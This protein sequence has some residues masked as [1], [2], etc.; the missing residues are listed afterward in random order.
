[1]RSCEALSKI[2]W[3]P[4]RYY[5]LFRTS[6]DTVACT[7][8]VADPLLG[9]VTAEVKDCAGGIDFFSDKDLDGSG[10]GSK[11]TLNECNVV[12][13]GKLQLQ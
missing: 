13:S 10:T 12:R 4:C 5:F 2:G 3:Q 8:L 6:L 1:M 11:V 7:I 9:A